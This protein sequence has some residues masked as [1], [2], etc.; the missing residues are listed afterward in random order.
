MTGF[1]AKKIT[2]HTMSENATT[3]MDR[4]EVGNGMYTVF[5]QTLS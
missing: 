4:V 3:Q 1:A 2:I 5:I